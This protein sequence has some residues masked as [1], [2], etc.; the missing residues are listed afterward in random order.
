MK[1]LTIKTG[2]CLLCAVFGLAACGDDLHDYTNKAASDDANMIYIADSVFTYP[3]SWTSDMENTETAT[4]TILARFPVHITEAVGN[5]VDVH[6]KL[7]NDMVEVYN[8]RHGTAYRI[9][10]ADS[11]AIHSTGSTST[12]RVTIAAGQTRSSDSISIS[13]K[14]KLKNLTD[15]NGYLIPVK[16]T[17]YS[18][19]GAAIDYPERLSYLIVN[20][21]RQNGVF[22]AP[23]ESSGKVTN[24]PYLGIYG[25]DFR[26]IKLKLSSYFPATKDTKV[27]LSVNN[28][29][30]AEYNAKNRTN[31]Q[32]VP[33]SDFTSLVVP[34]LDSTYS[35]PYKGDVSTLND[36][37]GYLVPFEITSVTGTNIDKVDKQKVFYAIL[38]QDDLH[39]NYVENETDLGVK[40]TDRSKFKIVKFVDLN[41]VDKTP[42]GMS[43]YPGGADAYLGLIFLDTYSVAKFW[44]ITVRDTKLDMTIDLGADIQN[45]TGLRLASDTQNNTMKAVDVYYASAAEYASGL[46]NYAGNVD[47]GALTQYMNVKISKPV[48][49]RYIRLVMTPMAAAVRLN[50][51]NIYT[52][53]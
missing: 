1:N 46:S 19:A 51:F 18:G 37:R 23:A 49:A 32:A 50:S 28:S 35:I 29:L 13:Y 43:S 34:K 8:S 52:N 15:P 42:S 47:K 3:L 53:N 25:S 44:M 24:N 16:I 4:D 20:V 2:L 40:K 5:N 33:E 14:G 30:I 45:V 7:D 48:T 41:G 22:F 11:L 38:D 27:T 10:P 21:S 12:N 39:I 9:I 17:T 26:N 31:Y 36:M 6:L